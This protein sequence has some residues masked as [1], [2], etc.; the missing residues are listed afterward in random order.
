MIFLD[1]HLLPGIFR[2]HLATIGHQESP[3]DIGLV[4][5]HRLWL[6]PDSFPEL[7]D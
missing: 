2:K 4:L 3:E 6:P 7:F 1:I 5:L